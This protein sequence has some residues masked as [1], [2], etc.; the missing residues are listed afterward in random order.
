MSN[1]TALQA[2]LIPFLPY[3]A[4]FD[5]FVSVEEIRKNYSTYSPD[6]KAIIVAFRNGRFVKAEAKFSEVDFNRL[7]KN[8]LVLVIS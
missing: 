7:L 3:L 2:L 8:D 1:I 5:D 6:S 4:K